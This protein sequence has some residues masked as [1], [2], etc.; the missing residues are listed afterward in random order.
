[1]N[2]VIISDLN[3]VVII[4]KFYIK[5]VQMMNI[6]RKFIEIFIQR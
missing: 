4:R 3:Y 1:M 2:T 6:D 5:V